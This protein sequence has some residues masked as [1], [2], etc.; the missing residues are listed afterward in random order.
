MHYEVELGLLIGSPLSNLSASDTIGAF[1]AISHYLL[2]IDM[3][4]RNVQDAAKKAGLPWTIGKGFDTFCPISQLVPRSRLSSEKLEEVYESEVWLDVN[5]EQRQRDRAELMLF[6]IP[7]I[8]SEI[9]GVMKLEVGDLVL[10]GTPKGVGEVRSGDVMT[11]GLSYGGKEVEEMSMRVDV[12][13]REGG[14]SFGS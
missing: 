2:A 12:R 1:S 11:A 5:G 10:T 4:A 9:S 7:R 8:L 14:Y 3:T 13:D 6:R